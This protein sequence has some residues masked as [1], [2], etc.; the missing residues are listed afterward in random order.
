M[1]RNSADSDTPD[2]L[3]RLLA[4]RTGQNAEEIE[5]EAVEMEIEAPDDADWEPLDEDW[6]DSPAHQEY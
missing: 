1:A 6:D 2:D 3:A 5:D 4:E